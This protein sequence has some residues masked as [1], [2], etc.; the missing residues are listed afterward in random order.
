MAWAPWERATLVAVVLVALALRLHG[1]AQAP[2]LTDNADELYFAWYGLNLIL[3]GDAYTWSYLP[4]YP[5]TTILH[6]YGTSFPLVHHSMDH[7]PLFGLIIGGWCWLTG[8]RGMLQVTA[9]QVRTLPVAFGTLS[10]LLVYLLGRRLLGPG[11]ALFGAAL[12]ATAPGAVLVSRQAEPESLQAV[13]LLAALLLTVRAIDGRA[14]P[15]SSAGLLVCCLAAPLLKV[16][17]IAVAGICAPILA[18]G[19]R[20]RLAGAT[21]GAAAAGLLLFALYGWLVDWSLFL[22]IWSDQAATRSGML[23]GFDF[24]AAAAG[25]NRSLHDGWWLLGWIGLGVLAAQGE[26][27][28]EL[29]LVWPAVAYAAA[30]LVLAAEVRVEQ[31]AWYRLIVYPSV[32]LGAGWLAWEAVRRAS[33]PLLTLLLVLGGAAATNWW[34]G[35][36]GAT[37]VPNPFLLVALMAAVLVPAALLARPSG[38]GGG[39]ERGAGWA[40]RLAHD[41]SLLRRWA[42]GAGVAAVGFMLIGN[43]VESLLLP[44]IF[45]HM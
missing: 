6:A 16:P 19:R 31:Y 30:M 13:L 18:A 10:V 5:S 22:R 44:V 27:R 26:P 21:L 32:E 11:P 4:G 12:L 15:W 25:I 39:A 24:I 38:W 7:P 8:A 1:L 42:L 43:V 14:G 23:S 36:G 45:T 41:S 33:L 2:R 3:H 17:G 29:F 20:W 9:V 35:G 34:L 37:W 28:R 40:V